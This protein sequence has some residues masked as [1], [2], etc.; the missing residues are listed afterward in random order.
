MNDYMWKR[1]KSFFSN[2]ILNRVP[3]SLHED[4][5]GKRE[6]MR[7]LLELLPTSAAVCIGHIDNTDGGLTVTWRYRP[8]ESHRKLV[9]IIWGNI[10]SECEEYVEH[11]GE[12]PLPPQTLSQEILAQVREESLKYAK[13][14]LNL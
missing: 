9:E 4:C 3:H 2:D 8:T 13:S 7:E 11:R 6:R 12:L 14:K 1:I 5:P 10:F